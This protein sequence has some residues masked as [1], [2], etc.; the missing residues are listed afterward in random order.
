MPLFLLFLSLFQ[1]LIFIYFQGEGSALMGR[2]NRLEQIVR[3]MKSVLEVPLTLKM[4]TGIYDNKNIAHT[5]IPKVKNWGVDLVTVSI[6]MFTPGEL[7]LSKS[8]P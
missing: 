1:Y 4:R 8:N 2:S 6:Y 5:L 7:S 3:G